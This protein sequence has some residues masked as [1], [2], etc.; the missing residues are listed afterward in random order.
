MYNTTYNAAKILAYFSEYGEKFVYDY[1]LISRLELID[2]IHNFEED[3]GM[4]LISHTNPA[5]IEPTE[6]FWELVSILQRSNS[7]FEEAVKNDL[8]KS[9]KYAFEN[10]LTLGLPSDSASTWALNCIKDYNKTRQPGLKLTVLADEYIT[11][12]MIL[13]ASIIFWCLGEK[14]LSEFKRH[15]HIEYKYY[16]FASDEYIARYGE[17]TVDN[18][19]NHRIIAYSGLDSEFDYRG[20]NWHISGKYGLPKLQPTIYTSSREMVSR[21]VADGVGIG[22]VCEKQEVYYGLQ[23]I[24]K[25]LASVEG[26]AIKSYFTSRSEEMSGQVALNIDLIDGLFKKYFERNGVKVVDCEDNQLQPT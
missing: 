21:L 12:S 9:D 2:I 11:S 1:F 24:R 17:P 3:L 16:L 19:Q 8:Q 26:P 18:I 23:G 6:K 5:I 20:S 15:W 25:V 4:K 13:N 14:E 10:E 22:S 7:T